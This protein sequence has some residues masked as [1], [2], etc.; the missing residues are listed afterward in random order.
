MYRPFFGIPFKAAVFFV[1]MVMLMAIPLIATQA[2]SYGQP[3][4]QP[5]VQPNEKL[6]ADL[7]EGGAE[8][9]GEVRQGVIQIMAS[10]GAGSGYIFD[11]EGHAITNRHVTG[12]EPTFEV[13]FWG[14]QEKS[15]KMGYRHKGILIGEDSALDMAIIQVEAPIEKFHPVK[16]GESG[17][18]VPGDVV[19]CCGSPGGNAQRGRALNPSD[20]MEGWLEYFNINLGVLREIV[21]FE[22]NFQFIFSDPYFALGYRE[23]YGSALEYIFLVDAAI[24]PGNSG[25]PLFNA[26]AEAVG[27]NTWGQ[28][29]GTN[30][31]MGF[32]APTDLLKKSA[33]DI[34]AYGHVRRPWVG[35]ALHPEIPEKDLNQLYLRGVFKTS[36]TW[37]DPRP[38]QLKILVVNPYSPAYEAGL[39]EGDVIELIDGKRIGYIFDIYSYFLHAKLGQEIEF[40]IRRGGNRPESIV[41]TVGEK[42]IRY[43]GADV[44]AESAVYGGGSYRLYHSPVTY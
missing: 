16:L 23:Y 27:T 28:G 35:I 11:K 14:E 21:P 9:F 6:V 15:R 3:T 7:I 22:D 12:H 18:M 20:P 26:Y 17:K 32:A 33:A 39:R 19:A 37:F 29:P 1:G 40:K 4:A 34:L 31:N 2:E 25:G 24:N 42:V 44:Y 8:L 10:G 38:A 13:A 41:V 30:E 5:N 43:F 36:G